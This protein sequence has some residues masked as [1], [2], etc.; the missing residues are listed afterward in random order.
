MD[1]TSTLGEFKR[2]VDGASLDKLEL[3]PVL[4]QLFAECR[5]TT[6]RSGIRA[7]DCLPLEPERLKGFREEFR[8]ALV[9]FIG[10]SVANLFAGTPP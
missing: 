9:R 4:R 5:V 1:L 6:V 10:Q 2:F 8:Q 3:S 7:L